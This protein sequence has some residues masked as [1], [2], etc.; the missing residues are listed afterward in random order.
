MTDICDICGL[1][2]SRRGVS[3]HLKEV[4]DRV[5]RSEGAWLLTLNT[6]MLARGSRDPDYWKMIQKADIIT[7]DG[8][9]LVWASNFKYPGRT[10]DGRTTGVDLVD[11]LLRVKNVP[12][13]AVI[14]G[15]SPLETIKTYGARTVEACA[16][17]YDGMVDLSDEQ[18]SWFSDELIRHQARV[19]FIALGVP[20]QDLLALEL[21]RKVPQAVLMG[22]GGTFEILGPKGGRAPHWMQRGGLEWL[23]R[24]AKDPG[25]LWKRYLINYP[26]GIWFLIKDC[27]VASK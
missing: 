4:T 10:I 7:A 8:M 27:L 20:K 26:R 12:K 16:F 25:R 3:D 5:G 11:A 6:E 22:I 18:L 14:G 21:R 19:V 2:V 24:L 17:V 1:T 9:P 15:K 23:Y 13:F